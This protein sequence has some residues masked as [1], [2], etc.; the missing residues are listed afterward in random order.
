LHV[1][2]DVPEETVGKR[3][4]QYRLVA[5]MTANDHAFQ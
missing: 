5:G 2:R 3:T 4:L 1:S